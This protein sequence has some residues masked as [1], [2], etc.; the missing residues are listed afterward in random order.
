MTVWMDPVLLIQS[1]ILGLN[2]IKHQYLI[3]K[4]WPESNT[5]LSSCHRLGQCHVTNERLREEEVV[6]WPDSSK[7]VH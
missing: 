5:L 7:E 3:N 2:L 6:S 4:E 1:F